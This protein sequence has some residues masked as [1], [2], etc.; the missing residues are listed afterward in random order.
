MIDD[1][2]RAGRLDGNAVAGALGAAYG[3]DVTLAVVR[4]V[5]CGHTDVVAR[6]RVHVS[7]MGAVVRCA[8]CDAV[9][10]VVVERPDGTL[11]SSPGASWVRG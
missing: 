8:T 11:V 5:S 6:T 7:P 9:L 3:I 1:A 2:Q 10:V 4:C